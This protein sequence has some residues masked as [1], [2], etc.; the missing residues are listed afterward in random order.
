MT[1][2]GKVVVL[3]PDGGEEF[4]IGADR[5]R[6]KGDRSQRSAAFSVI[7][8]EGAA[9]VGGP[10]PHVHRAFD[11][12]W[13]VLEGEVTFTAAGETIEARRGSYLFVPRRVPHTFE[14]KGRRTA[15]WVGIFSPGRY[16]GLVE[17]LGA[18]LPPG[19]APDPAKLAKLF[20]RYDSA[21]VRGTAPEKAQA[22][23][24]A[25][26]SGGV[27]VRLR[28]GV[29]LGRRGF[30]GRLGRRTSAAAQEDHRD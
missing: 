4:R 28:F 19:R 15:R 26:D 29:R 5:F 3:G 22:P 18:L 27:S 13:Y 6:T 30:H 9:G 12:A 21:I 8:Y 20:A 17:E 1:A 24:R 10:P 16:V 11:E 7:V 23:S 14:V 25:G 2:L